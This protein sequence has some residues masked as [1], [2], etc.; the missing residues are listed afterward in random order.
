[1]KSPSLCVW[2]VSMRC[3]YDV[4]L[5]VYLKREGEDTHSR[6]VS[7]R[8]VYECVVCVYEVC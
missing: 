5:L 8:C 7:M 2:G 6:N 4:C 3:V 1:M